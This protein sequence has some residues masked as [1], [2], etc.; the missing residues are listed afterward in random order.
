M[1]FLWSHS[2]LHS[3]IHSFFHQQT[4][5][6]PGCS[7][8][9]PDLRMRWLRF[10]TSRSC[11]SGSTELVWYPSLGE[12][13][14]SH[15]SCLELST[16]AKTAKQRCSIGSK[17]ALGRGRLNAVIKAEFHD[18]C[19]DSYNPYQEKNEEELYNDVSTEQIWASIF[20]KIFLLRRPWNPTR[21]LCW[22]ATEKN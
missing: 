4:L 14:S 18:L 2:F 21:I 15:F 12:T 19:T 11:K 1:V 6:E 16:Q 17:H 13:L 8:L 5:G 3:F 22:K 10:L 20:L 9:G 7:M